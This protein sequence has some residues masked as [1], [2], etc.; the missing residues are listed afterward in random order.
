VVGCGA[1]AEEHLPFLAAS[2]LVDLEAVCDLSPTLAELARDHYGARRAST[3]VDEV[4]AEVRPDVVHVLSPPRT[5]PG[6]IRRA[7][8]AGAH[9]ICEKPL[10]PSAD[11]TL[12]LLQ[13]ARDADRDLVETRNVLFNDVVIRLDQAIA[14]GRVGEIRE[15]DVAL[16]LDLA[17]ADVPLDGLGL[18]AGIAHDY[19][20]HLA[21][22]MLH[23]ASWHEEPGE[24]VGTIRNCSGAP[25]LG[26]DHVD[27]LISLGHVRARLRISPDVTPSGMRVTV[28]GTKGSLEADIY[29]PYLRHEGVPWVGNRSPFGFMVQGAALIR[30]GGRNVRDRV[31]Q[32]GTYHGMP[33]MLAALY[34]AWRDGRPLPISERDVLASAVLIDR[35]VELAGTSR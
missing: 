3:D 14:A 29:Q 23:V 13:S 11:E 28:R 15:I 16:A 31:L 9:V 33:R 35:I 12:S 26:F 27:V 34:E 2:D 17:N 20:P 10:A 1:I 8:A 18:P 22:L 30:A 24:V 6:L 4:L 25:E 21:Y 19:L 32:H 5:H 7:V